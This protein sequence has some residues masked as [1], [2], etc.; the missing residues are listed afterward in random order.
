VDE[1]PTDGGATAV[2]FDGQTSRKHRVTVTLAEQCEI[3]EDGETLATWPLGDIRRVDAPTGTLRLSCATDRPLARLEVRDAT[4]AG[5][6]AQRC[7]RLDEGAPGRSGAGRI[8]MW[9]ALALVS[10]VLVAIYGVPLAADRLTPLVPRTVEARLGEAADKQVRIIFSDK[11]C[12]AP[13]GQAA[14][15]KLMDALRAAG[16][17][18]RSVDAAVLSTPIPNAFAL[19]GGKVYLFSGLLEKAYNSDEIAGVLAHELGHISHRDSLRQL[20]YN[21]GT[22][23]LIGLLFGDISGSSALIFASR[24]MVEST[25]SRESEAAAD[26]FSIQVMHALGRPTRPMGELLHRVTGDERNHAL[27]FLSN[28]PFT[29]DRLALMQQEN[30]PANAPPILSD[31]EWLALRDICKP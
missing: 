5:L 9:S 27:S 7:V 8:V 1:A 30:R 6:I 24:T 16:G 11:L 20:I 29:E 14:F 28:H 31:E 19:P 10:I 21:G 26:R 2:Y 25:Y 17:L 4:L 18:D 15:R 3:T 12:D 13:K 22:S 23:Y